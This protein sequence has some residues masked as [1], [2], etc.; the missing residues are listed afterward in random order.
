MPPFPTVTCKLSKF[1]GSGLTSIGG[2][3]VGKIIYW[4]NTECSST[5]GTG[6]TM[7]TVVESPSSLPAEVVNTT[8]G[9]GV[10]KV[11]KPFLNVE[12]AGPVAFKCTYTKPVM[13][14]TLTGGAHAKIN[15]SSGLTRTAGTC[16]VSA[17]FTASYEI[18]GN[19]RRCS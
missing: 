19:R 12:C 7:G 16:P 17:T 15:T 10:I 11:T 14:F 13:E 9:N 1:N 2:P 6:C 5:S 3:L 4:Y 18:P 8:S